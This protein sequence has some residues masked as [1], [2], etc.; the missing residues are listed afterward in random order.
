VVADGKI[1]KHIQTDGLCLCNFNL[2][3]DPISTD[4]KTILGTT[5]TLVSCTKF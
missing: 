3:A 4:L 2:L 5:H 1:K